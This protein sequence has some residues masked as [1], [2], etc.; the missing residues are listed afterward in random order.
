[1]ITKR[2]FLLAALNG[3]MST[4]KQFL[5][6]SSGRYAVNTAVK[7]SPNFGINSRERFSLRGLKGLWYKNT[8]YSGFNYY[9]DQN[10]I[11]YDH[12][13]YHYVQIP[14]N[15][16]MFRYNYRHGMT[17]LSLAAEM[18]H[19][20]I[21]QAL[22][23]I[24]DIRV[25]ATDSNGRSPLSLAA[26]YGHTEVV[27]AL[28]E[29]RKIEVNLTDGFG[30][31]ALMIAA[32][33]DH[34]DALRVL[35]ESSQIEINASN[36]YGCSALMLA[37]INGNTRCTKELIND[38]RIDLKKRLYLP[39]GLYCLSELNTTSKN[40]S[41]IDPKYR[42]L[43]PSG[44]YSVEQLA[45]LSGQK[46]IAALIRTKL[47]EQN[48][49]KNFQERLAALNKAIIVPE[50]LIC[51]ISDSIINDPVTASN[52]ITYDRLALQA[53][54][55]N[56]NNPT[57]LYCLG[58]DNPILRSELSN[59][60]SVV[61]YDDLE[62]FV[63]QQEKLHQEELEDQNNNQ[64]DQ[65]DASEAMG[66]VKNRNRLFNSEDHGLDEDASEDTFSHKTPLENVVTCFR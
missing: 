19:L 54:F 58:G 21:V 18:G 55:R 6:S 1:M 27:R 60:T 64:H 47:N 46:E 4:V 53:F 48:P 34:I 22:L 11:T 2:D 17:A 56:A 8:Y 52:G 26:M 37:I 23:D 28:L 63:Q 40:H 61:V 50:H 25:N 65:N 29:H 5:S 43:V 9:H 42:T 30:I 62:A 32:K 15:V 49:K 24:K 38:P 66:S 16:S 57:A 13:D 39:Y 45:E 31:S 10:S 33:Y 7:Y 36:N 51:P 35:L 12:Q 59:T 20:Y 14:S 44:L 3:D 41:K